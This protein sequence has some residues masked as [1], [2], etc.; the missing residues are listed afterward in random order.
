MLSMKLAGK[1]CIS[2]NPAQHSVQIEIDN[3]DFKEGRMSIYDLSGRL[4]LSKNIFNKEEMVN[5]A[6]LKSGEYICTVKSDNKVF[7][8]KFVKAQ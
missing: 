6:H 4:I 1:L 5:I 2:P 8:S 7:V 3:P